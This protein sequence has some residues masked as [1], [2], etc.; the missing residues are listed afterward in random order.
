[1]SEQKTQQKLQTFRGKIEN[2]ESKNTRSGLA[3]VVF[4]VNG[5]PS[6]AFGNQAEAVQQ[7]EGHHAEITAR[8]NTYKG[9][10]EYAVVTIAGEIGGRQVAVTDTSRP[11]PA[12]SVPQQKLKHSDRQQWN[13]RSYGSDVKAREVGIWLNQ[14]FDDLT[15]T[16]WEQWKQYPNSHWP[17]HDSDRQAERDHNEKSVRQFKEGFECRNGKPYPGKDVDILCSCARRAMPQDLESVK[18]RFYTRLDE[19]RGDLKRKASPTDPGTPADVR[20]TEPP[21]SR[22]TEGS[23]IPPTT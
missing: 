8:H 12:S 18:A 17:I 1:M 3:M 2:V 21:T 4:K 9:K 13:L 10:D 14:F 11:V 19:V 16:E 20:C 5:Y 7:L 15:E 6:K 22:S 23:P